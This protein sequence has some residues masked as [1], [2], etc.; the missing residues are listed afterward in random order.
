MRRAGLTI[1]WIGFVVYAFFL[2]PPNQPGTSDLILNLVTGQWQGINPAII[3]V[4]NLLGVYPMIYA[5]VALI[6]GRSQRIWAW[7]FVVGSFGAG[8][9]AL[10]PYLILRQPARAGFQP[11]YEPQLKGS[12]S[13]LLRL[14]DSRW[15]GLSL[16]LAALALVGFGL[17][18][19][20]WSDFFA[21]WRTSRFINVM[22][23]DFC[24]LWALFPTLLGDDM[25]RRGLKNP[26]AFWA[27]ALVPLVGAAAYLVWRPPLEQ[28]S[29]GQVE[30]KGV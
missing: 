1:L 19:G 13:W 29:V 2:A 14:L 7:P 22:S 25:A 20:D 24:L 16:L 5:C 28:A 11:S 3:A 21:Q 8:A 30:A 10:L 23:L 18:G 6:D 27:V 17:I 26:A 9:F 12:K 15:L 4:F